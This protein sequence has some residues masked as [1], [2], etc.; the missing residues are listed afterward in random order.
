MP[1]PGDR[2]Q[3]G[4]VAIVFATTILIVG[5]AI[6]TGT[7]LLGLLPE[8]QRSRLWAL[9]ASAV[10]YG[11]FA[12]LLALLGAAT[13]CRRHLG[14]LIV[15]LPVVTT[16]V[17]QIA[18]V[19]PYFPHSAPSGTGPRFTLM[20]LNTW[21][22]RAGIADLVAEVDSAK[23]DVIV[24]VEVTDECLGFIQR[25]TIAR[26]YPYRI[27]QAGNRF[28]ASGLMILSRFPLQALPTDLPTALQI[29]KVD[30][31][32]REVVVAAVHPPN[33]F[34]NHPEWLSTSEAIRKRLRPL[35]GQRLVVA[36]DF[37]ATADHLTLRRILGI[38]LRDA[39]V[40]SGSGWQ[41]TWPANKAVPPVIAIDHVLIG[42]LVS[43]DEVAAFTVPLT[44]HRGLVA[45]LRS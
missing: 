41:P 36:G 31:R 24:L 32:G 23:P 44:D 29:A 28:D 45:R 20:S 12:W 2:P 9:L 27:G 21:G 19:A 35:L 17:I 39:A 14:W 8:L 11:V 40:T 16:L 4:P 30:I 34:V 42:A 10:P 6:G 3:P 25:T 7:L 5:A 43:A 26:T 18:W 15:A 1:T 13:L 33:P 22:G 38:G 37:N